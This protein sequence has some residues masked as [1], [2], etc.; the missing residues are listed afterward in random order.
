MLFELQSSIMSSAKYHY[1]CETISD[2]VF[3]EKI[4]E[5]A[6]ILE[7][8]AEIL[9]FEDQNCSL[10]PNIQASMDELKELLEF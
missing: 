7:E 4:Q 6:K 1:A 3:Q 10:M 5:A 2:E 8:S 9:K